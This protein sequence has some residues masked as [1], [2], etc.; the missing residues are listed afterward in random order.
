MRE[1]LKIS[2]K[3]KVFLFGAVN[4]HRD[5][6]KGGD[7]LEKA[8][9]SLPKFEGPEDEAPWFV[10][11]GGKEFHYKTDNG[12]I[13]HGLGKLVGDGCLAEVYASADLFL[14]PSREDNLPNTCVEAI[15]SGVPV[16]AFDVGGLSDIVVAGHSGYLV[17]P[18]D[19]ENFSDS[20]CDAIHGR[21]PLGLPDACRQLALERFSPE[22]QIKQMLKVYRGL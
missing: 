2:T 20:L 10:A 16:L 12:Y 1:K 19:L 17:K 13:R 14:C 18:F 21:I 15:A 6:R 11:F 8:I 5:L 22:T 4:P 3:G 7:L 9:L